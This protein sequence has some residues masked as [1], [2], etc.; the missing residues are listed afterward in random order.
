MHVYCLF[1]A[2]FLAHE[3]LERG[4]LILQELVITLKSVD[5]SLSIASSFMFIE[6]FLLKLLDCLFIFD[7]FKD[8]LNRLVC[9]LL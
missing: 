3:T 8:K 2:V 9:S 4:D 7:V 5:F 1:S 6:K